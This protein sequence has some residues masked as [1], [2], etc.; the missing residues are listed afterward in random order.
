MCNTCCRCL[1]F[2]L[3]VILC[4]VFVYLNSSLFVRCSISL[5]IVLHE[6]TCVLLNSLV[7]NFESVLFLSAADVP[8]I[9]ISDSK[10][11]FRDSDDESG[12]TDEDSLDEID[13]ACESIYPKVP[14]PKVVVSPSVAL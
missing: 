14:A 1:S 13:D 2:V 4:S 5:F 6:Q 3:L 12:E 8:H 7:F 9:E 11:S 10:H